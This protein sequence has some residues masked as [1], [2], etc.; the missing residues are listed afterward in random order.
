MTVMLHDRPATA[1][2]HGRYAA[3][4]PIDGRTS[5]PL[6]CL[7]VQRWPYSMTPVIERA[8]DL[9]FQYRARNTMSYL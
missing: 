7:I 9:S 5:L 1:V 4:S 3:R 6:C 8:Q 2:P